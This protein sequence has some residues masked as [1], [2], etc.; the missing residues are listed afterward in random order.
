MKSLRF[1]FL[2]RTI[3]LEKDTIVWRKVTNKG[4]KLF[5][6]QPNLEMLCLFR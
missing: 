4:I 5:H 1:V 6:S 2:K 3:V